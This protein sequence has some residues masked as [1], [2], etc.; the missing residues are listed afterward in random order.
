M[1]DEKYAKVDYVGE[2]FSMFYNFLQTR[3]SRGCTTST[4]VTDWL[5]DSSLSS[6]PLTNHC[7]QTDRARDTMATI[8][9][10]SCDTCHVS[11]VTCQVSGV[12][13]QTSHVTPVK[14]HVSS[15]TCHVSHVT[16]TCHMSRVTIFF[17]NVVKLVNIGSVINRAYPV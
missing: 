2:I 3:C 9:Y 7:A 6:K 15:A 14:C 12:T 5:T 10:V 16:C 17:D 8:P 4:F 13:C 11:C 1:E